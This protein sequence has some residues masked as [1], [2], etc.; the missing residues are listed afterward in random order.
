MPNLLRKHG[1]RDVTYEDEDGRVFSVLL[2]PNAPDSQ[3]R[4]GILLGPLLDLAELGLPLATEI[5]LHNALQSRGVL[6]YEDARRSPELVQSALM[7]ALKMDARRV[8]ESYSRNAV[9]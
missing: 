8:I 5:R 6:T 2:P 9:D 1:Y 7:A 3:A 4:S